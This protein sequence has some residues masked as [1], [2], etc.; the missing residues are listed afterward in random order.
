MKDAIVAFLLAQLIFSP[1]YL[2][3][4]LARKEDDGPPIDEENAEITPD[5]CEDHSEYRRALFVAIRDLQKA[6]AGAPYL[7]S[8]W[9]MDPDRETA[10][11]AIRL[12]RTETEKWADYSTPDT[13]RHW[14]KV[15][16]IYDQAE[17]RI[18]GEGE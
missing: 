7:S 1:I 9:E 15:M 3:I 4:Y 6:G 16:S 14:K 17:E 11:A 5:L 10:L 18:K 2:A 13:A 8:A 12:S